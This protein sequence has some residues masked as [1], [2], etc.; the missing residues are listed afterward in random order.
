MDRSEMVYYSPANSLNGLH[1][2]W[3]P[4]PTGNVVTQ[5]HSAHAILPPRN[6]GPGTQHHKKASINEAALSPGNEQVHDS[7]RGCLDLLSCQRDRL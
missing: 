2:L 3:L 5:I 6:P 4:S 7:Q 1:Q